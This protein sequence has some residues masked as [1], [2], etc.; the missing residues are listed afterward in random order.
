[1]NF[2]DSLKNFFRNKIWSGSFTRLLFLGLLAFL[3]FTG[4]KSCLYSPPGV[5]DRIYR[6][7]RDPAWIGENFR[8]K[9]SNITGFS[10]RLLDDIAR[11]GGFRIETF[12]SPTNNLVQGLQDDVFDA[13]FSD[14]PP[15]ISNKEKYVFSEPYYPTGPVL[16]VETNAPQEHLEDFAGK[17]IGIYRNSRLLIQGK[18][19]KTIVVFPY[20]SM[21]V[22]IDDLIRDRIDGVIIDFFYGYALQS[23]F[24]SGKIKVIP[25]VLNNDALRLVAMKNDNMEPLIEAFNE[26]LK[27]DKADGTYDNLLKNFDLPN[28]SPLEE[29]PAQ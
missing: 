2:L 10:D 24:Y 29:P 3:A 27:K 8:G 28:I 21:N 19:P 6:I 25:H 20:D 13:I 1:M 23:G 7:A 5:K 4:I 16:V 26:G 14:M 15:D 12:S 17:T 18:I 22:A 9:E 11:K